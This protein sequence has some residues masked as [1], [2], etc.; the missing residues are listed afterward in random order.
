MV[1]Y[2][3]VTDTY[4]VMFTVPLILPPTIHNALIY[5]HDQMDSVSNSSKYARIRIEIKK[6][7]NHNLDLRVY[8][9]Y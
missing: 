6:N 7:G 4:G 5:I 9:Y 8:I 3:C 1:V 2:V